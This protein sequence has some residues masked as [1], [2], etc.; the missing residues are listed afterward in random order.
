MV[1]GGDVAL[2]RLQHLLQQRR[3]KTHSSVASEVLGG[4]QFEFD[5]RQFDGATECPKL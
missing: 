2:Q 5:R 4:V 1:R 3:K